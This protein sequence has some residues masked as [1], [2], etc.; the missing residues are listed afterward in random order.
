MMTASAEI[1]ADAFNAFEAEGWEGRAGGYHDFFA[2]ITRRPIEPLLDAAAVGPGASLLDVATGPGYVA[3]AA[4]ARE[5]RPTGVDVA[6]EMVELARRLHPGIP[7]VQGD[8][9]RLPFGD[10]SFDAAVANFAILHVGRP[11]R[12]AAELARVLRPGGRVALTVWDVPERSRLMG[13]FVDAVAEAGAAPPPSVP[14]GPDF[15]RFSDAD[16]FTRLLAGA[17]LADESV[18]AIEFRHHA[19]SAR[20]IWDGMLN[21]TV[22]IRALVDDQD[23]ETR[24]RIRAA[25]ERLV[26]ECDSATGIEI[27]VAVKL[28]SARKPD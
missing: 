9:E 3:G 1:D 12:A 16:Q 20:E 19:T 6:A 7:F 8:A 13:V 15:F 26:A 10:A 25:F 27:P 24:R 17:G 11:E 2:S 4:Q 18:E 23:N 28:A 14:A 21:G 5:A 22:R